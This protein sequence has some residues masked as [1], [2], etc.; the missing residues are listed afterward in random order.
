MRRHP[1]VR[2][3]RSILALA[4]VASVPAVAL[5]F[6]TGGSSTTPAARPAAVSVPVAADPEVVAHAVV[7]PSQAATRKPAAKPVT[8]AAVKPVRKPA[9]RPV[10]KRIAPK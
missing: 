7:A 10:A 6:L 5:G 1:P 4:A 2:P 3:S 9:A 8:K